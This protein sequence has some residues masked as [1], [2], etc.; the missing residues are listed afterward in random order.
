[1]W[2]IFRELTAKFFRDVAMLLQ[3]KI[4]FMHGNFS[5]FLPRHFTATFLHRVKVTSKFFFLALQFYRAVTISI[6][7]QFTMTFFGPFAIGISANLPRH[8]L[9]FCRDHIR[10]FTVIVTASSY[11]SLARVYREVATHFSVSLP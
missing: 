8:Q 6:F 3:Q 5:G 9:R 1:V 10:K 4:F 7:A 2:K 11:H